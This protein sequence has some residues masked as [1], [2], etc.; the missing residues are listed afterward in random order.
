MNWTAP[1]PDYLTG[2]CEWR[3]VRT[4][5]HSYA[6]WL[7][8]QRVLFDLQADPE[9][10]WDTALNKPRILEQLRTELDSTVGSRDPCLGDQVVP[11]GATLDELKALGYLQ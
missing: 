8:G 6:R 9:E 10:L 7:D 1:D 3:G 4:L 11:T 5:T 2:G